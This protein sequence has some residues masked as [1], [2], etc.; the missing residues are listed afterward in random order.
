MAGVATFSLE[1]PSRKM[2]SLSA[3]LAFA[4]FV[5]TL[6]AQN[7][8]VLSPEIDAADRSVTFRLRSPK[9]TEVKL[10]TQ[11]NKQTPAMQKG[12][13]GLWS[14][15]VADVP[16]GVWEYGFVVDGLSVVD[17]GNPAIKPQRNPNTSILHLPG[18]PPNPWDFQDVPH[19]AVHQHDFAGRAAGRP[20]SV[21]VYTPS[22]YERDAARR[23]P[24]LVL[25]HGS[26][27]NHK[28]WVEHGKAHWILDNLIAAG[29]APPM[30]GLML[31][32]HPLGA[33]SR[34]ATDR[35]TASLTAFRRELL[36]EALPLVESLYR[37][38]P[39]REQR[40]IA[41]LSMGGWQ[42]LSVGLNALDRFAW[43]GSFSG[44]VEEKEIAPALADATGTNAQVKLLWIACGKDDFLLARNQQ[45]V[46]TLQ[47]RGVKHE[48]VQTAGDHSWPIWRGYLADFLPRLFR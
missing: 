1:P 4:G 3:T 13:G 18:T 45:L 28:T 11:W 6:A 40:A 31:D 9:A 33:V 12:E 26:G 15:R 24:L 22:G 34:E 20:R 2:K 35:R 44:A 25:Q 46:A 8:P 10:R 17:P 37:V 36:E 48:W 42:S 7:A 39:H 5:V 47:A 30:I 41:G 38:S 16:A 27:D 43:I 14:L 32:G 29:K 21:W 19:G 23:Y